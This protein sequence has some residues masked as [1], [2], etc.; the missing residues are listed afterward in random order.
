MDYF[1]LV[2]H[3]K[4]LKWPINFILYRMLFKACDISKTEHCLEYVFF[5][6]LL[7]MQ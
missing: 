6:T 3:P 4:G 7:L 1:H 2:F 5:V